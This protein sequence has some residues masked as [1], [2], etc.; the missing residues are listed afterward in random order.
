LIKNKNTLLPKVWKDSKNKPISCSEK[1]KILN[2]NI[3][4]INRMMED[5]IEDAE[6]MGA[7]SNQVINILKKSID[8]TN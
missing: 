4:E 3:L 6:L 5:A 7:D 2:E 1:I 8:S